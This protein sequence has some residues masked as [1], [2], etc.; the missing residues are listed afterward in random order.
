MTLNGHV[1]ELHMALTVT[2]HAAHMSPSSSLTAPIRDPVDDPLDQPRAVVFRGCAHGLAPFA[3][4]EVYAAGSMTSLTG[5]HPVAPRPKG[6][7]G[8]A[9]KDA[10]RH[11]HYPPEPI[12]HAGRFRRMDGREDCGRRPAGSVRDSW[13]AESCRPT[14]GGSGVHDFANHGDNRTQEP[15]RCRAL[16]KKHKSTRPRRQFGNLREEL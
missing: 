9:A 10:C 3:T 13:T 15:A 1:A 4:A 5:V 7:V 8:T 16:H 11:P 6:D 14:L 12:V 2:E